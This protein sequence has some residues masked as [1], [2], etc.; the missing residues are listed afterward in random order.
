ML[1]PLYFCR[2]CPNFVFFRKLETFL[3][4]VNALDDMVKPSQEWTNFHREINAD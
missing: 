2:K 1:T 4:S 3:F